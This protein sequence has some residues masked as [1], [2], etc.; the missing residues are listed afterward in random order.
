MKTNT[1]LIFLFGFLLLSLNSFSQEQDQQPSAVVKDQYQIKT[2]FSHNGHRASGGYGALTNKFTTINGSFAN[3]AEVYGGWYINHHFLVGIS[4]A[5]LTNNIHV[6]DAY[7]TQPGISMSYEYGQFGLM[8]EY[9]LGSSKA[10]HLS[11][12]L[13]N[14]AGFTVQYER[15]S[16]YDDND[17]ENN[18]NYPHDT[19]WFFVTEPGVQV[20]VNIFR[21]MRFSPGISYRAAFGSNGLGLSDNKLSGASGN[22]T[23]K[24]GKF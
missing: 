16:T 5:A 4:G 23:L 13:F 18:N 12:Q 8:N 11:F 20:E 10:V 7:S 14:G 6:P 2:I 24:F 21:W 9:T 22:L 17:W 1:R 3:L 19:N 15:P